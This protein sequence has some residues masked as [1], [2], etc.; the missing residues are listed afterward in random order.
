MFTNTQDSSERLTVWRGIRQDTTI[1]SVED[2]LTRFQ[3]I[4]PKPRYIDY[5]TPSSWPNVFNIVTDGYFCQSGITL[6][7]AATMHYFRFINSDKIRL[8]AISNYETGAEGL[9]LVLDGFCYN[10]TPGQRV[11]LEY[12]TQN[13]TRY[14]SHI[15]TIDKLFD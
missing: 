2:I 6:V 11:T 10:F 8:D 5:Y 1:Q 4:K 13:S 15:I 3:S 7:M 9:V 12:A 14:D